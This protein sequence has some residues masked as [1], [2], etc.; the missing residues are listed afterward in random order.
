M[1]NTTMQFTSTGKR[2]AFLRKEKSL[3]QQGFADFLGVSRS[4]LADIERERS[5]PSSNFLVQLT[6]KMDVSTDWILT[7]QGEML[8]NKPSIASSLKENILTP[9]DL[10][11]EVQYSSYDPSFADSGQVATQTQGQKNNYP[12]DKNKEAWEQFAL[13]PLYDVEAS[14]GWGRLVDQELKISDMAFRTD[15]LAARGLKPSHCAL[16]R[17]RGDSME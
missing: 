7:G 14:A 2:I 6:T 8:K 9:E 5:E 15:W 10:G 16:I 12:V 4:Y 3:S 13:V 1:S 17:A 11:I